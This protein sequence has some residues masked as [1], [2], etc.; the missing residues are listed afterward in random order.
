MKVNKKYV[1][2]RPRA[3]EFECPNIYDTYFLRLT[4]L[5]RKQIHSTYSRN[6]FL[7]SWQCL[8]IYKNIHVLYIQIY[9]YNKLKICPKKSNILC[10]AIFSN[11]WYIAKIFKSLVEEINLLSNPDWFHR[12]SLILQELKDL[13]SIDKMIN[14]ML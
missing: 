1:D 3:E 2:V 10:L 7:W 11:N 9:W 12:L 13:E 14:I 6:I 5:L 8:L 4:C